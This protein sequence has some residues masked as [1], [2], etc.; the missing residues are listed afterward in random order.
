[1][2]TLLL[3]SAA[4]LSLAAAPAM[5]DTIITF[6]QV[7]P[8]NTVTGT[9]DGT[10]THL[11]GSDVLVTITQI[12]AG[13]LTPVNAFLDFTADSTSGATAPPSNVIVQHF[14][15]SFSVNGAADGSGTNYL[16]GLFLDGVFGIRGGTG[17]T[18]T[19]DGIFA[20]DVITSLDP[21][22]N[23]SLSFTNV[24]PAA[25]TVATQAQNSLDCDPFTTIACNDTGW[26]IRTFAASV[27]GN[28][29]AFATPAPEPASLALLGLGLAGLAVA[30]RRS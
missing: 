23:F 10:G 27:S 18:L 7:S 3:A 17:Y 12:A 26:T 9:A 16:S 6:G 14:A 13:V 2:R 29:S 4:A 8:I 19:A 25:D 21:P 20:S 24:T 28:A 5:A 30:R 22:R 11:L 1:M 15:G